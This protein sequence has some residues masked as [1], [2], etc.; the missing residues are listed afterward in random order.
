MRQ[1]WPVFGPFLLANA[2]VFAYID[3]ARPFSAAA[4]AFRLHIKDGMGLRVIRRRQQAVVTSAINNNESVGTGPR[5]LPL[6]GVESTCRATS[7]I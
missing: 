2:A 7:N 5:P 1:Q 3:P 4:G 6:K